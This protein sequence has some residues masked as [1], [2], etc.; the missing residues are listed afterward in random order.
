[1]PR[2]EAEPRCSKGNG[3]KFILYSH[4]AEDVIQD[5]LGEPEYG[6]CFALKAFRRVLAELG[7]VE[8][9]RSPDIEVRPIFAGC[10]ARGEVCLFLPFGPAH[11]SPL[12]LECPTV[13]V[14]AWEFTTSPNGAGGDDPQTD[15]RVA[16]GKLGHAVALSGHS[17]RVIAETMG[18]DFKI[19][20]VPPPVRT[21]NE[22]A[23]PAEAVSTGLEIESGAIIV[24]TAR[25]D[26][27]VDV[28]A[29]AARPRANDSPSTE[30]SRPR[31]SRNTPALARPGEGQI[32]VNAGS[33]VYTSVLNPNDK[34]KN[35]HD[36]VT[37]FCWAFRDVRDTTLI[38]K[39]YDPGL[40]SFYGGL[41]PIL[42]KLSPFRCRVVV[43]P[44]FLQDSDYDR[45]IRAT[46]Y[47][48]TASASE[49][50]CVPLM[51]FMSCGKPA[52][53]AAQTAMADYIDSDVAFVLR[54]T[55]QITNWPDDPRGLFRT[56]SFRL[57]WE[58][59]RDAFE[60]SYRLARTSPHQYCE[61][62]KRARSR[63]HQYASPE[64]VRE[65]L[66]KFFSSV[67]VSSPENS[68]GPHSAAEDH[69]GRK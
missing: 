9:V 33:V 19:S 1:M 58:S 45:L 8:V 31:T 30:R 60:Q 17:A 32:S 67:A 48:V 35:A 4:F 68:H 10:R 34:S 62:S 27:E 7:S 51:E 54:A 47:C 20:V 49:G 14:I 65:T 22:E 61:M 6:Y 59:L 2:W 41:I 55:R 13:P 52:L 15:W 24:D 23:F 43:L 29:P 63:M 18:P 37:A 21:R 11:K 3:V 69:A 36:L 66:C 26:L 42:Y 57:E 40:Q 50:I 12:D 56:M 44:G 28:L 25:M 38:L 16:L 5:H 53:A 39:V 64:T 46:T